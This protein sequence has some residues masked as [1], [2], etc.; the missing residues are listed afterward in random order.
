MESI[1]MLPKNSII[2]GFDGA[3]GGGKTTLVKELAKALRK[4]GYEVGV[5]TEV[6]RDVFEEFREKYGFN[7]LSEIRASPKIA[8]FQTECLKLQ[9]YLENQMLADRCQIILTDRTLFGNEFFTILYCRDHEALNSYMKLLYEYLN[10]R[11][12]DYGK[13]YDAVVIFPP[14]PKSVNVDDGFRTPDLNYRMAQTLVIEQ[15]AAAHVDRVVELKTTNLEERI[16]TIKALVE[17]MVERVD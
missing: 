12:L 1:M 5:I 16:N 3:S 13:V 9:Y 17:E 11:I 4:E 7:S 6:V 8:E 10:L 14:L 2:I 15:L